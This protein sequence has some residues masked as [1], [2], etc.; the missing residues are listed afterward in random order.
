MMN[1]ALFYWNMNPVL[2]KIGPLTLHW[3][4]VFFATAFISGFIIMQWTYKRE[5]IPEQALD[6]LFFY[7]FFGTLVGA[8]VGHCFFYDPVYYASHPIAILK[9]WEGGLASH[10]G[11]LGIL[12]ALF[13]YTRKLG[14]PSYLWMLDRVAI[15]AA[16]GGFFIRTGNFFNSEIVGTPTSGWLGVV[17][18]RVD[19]VPR[20]AVQLYESLVYGIIFLL[21]LFVYRRY[22]KNVREGLLLGIFLVSVFAVRI[23]LEFVKAPQAAYEANWVFSVGQLLS[24]PFIVLGVTLL[25]HRRKEP[26]RCIHEAYCRRV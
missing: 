24:M 21:L 11:A 26:N 22:G 12:I 10:G 14:R 17:F 18:E 8:R 15:P 1:K 19:Q 25:M 16:L 3:Y 13:I 5:G 6:N 23:V 4:G 7:L 2:V 20:H 9:I